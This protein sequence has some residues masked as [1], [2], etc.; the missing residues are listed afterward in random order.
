[1]FCGCLSMAVVFPVASCNALP[2]KPVLL[3]H[4]WSWKIVET[5]TMPIG[6]RRCGAVT[7]RKPGAEPDQHLDDANSH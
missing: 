6:N 2:G 7:C 4:G 1:M 5:W 3:V